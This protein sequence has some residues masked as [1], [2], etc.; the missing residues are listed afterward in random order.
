MYLR[1]FRRQHR[2]SGPARLVV[3]WWE[4]AIGMFVLFSRLGGWHATLKTAVRLLF[5]CTYVRCF[6]SSV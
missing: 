6:L 3:R 2:A 4:M 5:G 1:A